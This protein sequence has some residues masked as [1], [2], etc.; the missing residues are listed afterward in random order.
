M[1]ELNKLKK[2]KKD[3]DDG[4]KDQVVV[5]R[6][7]E[8]DVILR[9]NFP[10][11]EVLDQVLET[12]VDQ[13]FQHVEGARGIYASDSEGQD[14]EYIDYD[15]TVENKPIIRRHAHQTAVTNGEWLR[16]KLEWYDR[17]ACIP[18]TLN[19]ATL[20]GKRFLTGT[21]R[22]RLSCVTV[23]FTCQAKKFVNSFT[24]WTH[25]GHKLTTRRLV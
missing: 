22:S 14:G 24:K 5:C 4:K 2:K 15:K 23:S 9:R 18:G 7:K 6:V 17:N 11:N 10:K 25:R 16:D 1:Q 13:R 20:G 3:E 8:V 21:R 12:R 19:D